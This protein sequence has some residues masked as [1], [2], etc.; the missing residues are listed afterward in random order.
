MSPS[1]SVPSLS[2]YC[3]RPCSGPGTKLPYGSVANM[4]MSST[5]LS[6]SWRPSFAAACAF[7]DAQVAMPLAPLP[8]PPSSLPVSTGLPPTRLYSRRKT[9]CDGCDVYVW[10]WST[11][12]ESVFVASWTSSA[13]SS[14]GVAGLSPTIPSGPGWFWA[15]VST[16]NAWRAGTSSRVFALPSGPSVMSGTSGL[17][18]TKTVEPLLTV[19]S[20]PWSKNWPKNVNSELN[21]GERPTSVV[22]FGMNSDL[23]AGVQPAGTP[24]VV[25]V[26]SVVQMNAVAVGSWL[27]TG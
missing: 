2:T 14:A 22:T 11:Q 13:L 4:G 23:C 10:L 7:T 12:G 15:R 3:G 16:M 25:A 8:V 27:R 21:G 1:R 26:G 20:T 6:T 19:W 18:G 9:W 24:G 17:S 5:S